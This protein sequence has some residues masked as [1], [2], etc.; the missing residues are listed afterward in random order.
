MPDEIG[1]GV[2]CKANISYFNPLLYNSITKWLIVMINN[3][4]EKQ[5][6]FFKKYPSRKVAADP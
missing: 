5:Q 1:I 4:K 6:F 3:L 2:Y